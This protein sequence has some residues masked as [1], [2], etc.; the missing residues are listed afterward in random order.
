MKG[1]GKGDFL[2]KLRSLPGLQ[3]FDLFCRE[4]KE[5]ILYLF[6]G[7]LAFLLNICLF[8][9]L[10]GILHLNELVA[11]VITWILCVLF[12]FFTN[13]TWVFDG[14]VNSQLAFFK[15]MSGF[16]GG[17][18]LTLAVEEVILAVFTT[19]LD[20]NS[21]VVKLAGQVIVI[22]LNYIVSKLWVFKSH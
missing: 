20:F 3:V 15:Q 17:R 6:F 9:L 16:F 8:I 13:R 21:M 14:H 10:H 4:H 2:A 7:G 12:Q 1:L 5:G 19:W 18:L 22:I 11:N